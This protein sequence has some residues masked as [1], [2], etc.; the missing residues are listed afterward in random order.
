MEAFLNLSRGLRFTE[1]DG[2]RKINIPAFKKT[3]SARGDGFTASLE[4]V[5]NSNGPLLVGGSSS[6]Q[7]DADM[8]CGVISVPDYEKREFSSRFILPGSSVKGAIRSRV[9]QICSHLGH[10]ADTVIR[11]MFGTE[12]EGGRRGKVRIQDILLPINCKTRKVQHVAIDRFTGGALDAAL[13]NEAPIWMEHPLTFTFSCEVSGLSMLE[14]GLFVHAILD[15]AEGRL[16][17]GGGV[18]RGNG[19]LL[20]KGLD[21]DNPEIQKR[22][23]NDLNITI[24][25]NQD[26]LY[27]T[28]EDLHLLKRWS[29]E[30]DKALNVRGENHG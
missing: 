20:L 30:I 15:L 5:L 17:I 19:R 25:K 22:H 14:A 6:W 13:F 29:M 8:T 16:P 27:S 9:W 2:G 1:N 12:Q 3:P 21:I 7:D 10:D 24:R 4:M 28:P 26:E 18:N 11:E 23:L